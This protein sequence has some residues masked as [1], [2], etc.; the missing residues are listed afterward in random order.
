MFFRQAIYFEAIDVVYLFIAAV[1]VF[2]IVLVLSLSIRRVFRI[3]KE[4]FDLP[5][6]M[7]D[8]LREVFGFRSPPHF[9]LLIPL[10]ALVVGIFLLGLGEGPRSVVLGIGA[11]TFAIVTVC[12]ALPLWKNMHRL[13]ILLH[14]EAQHLVMLVFPLVLFLCFAVLL[15]A[16]KTLRQDSLP[17]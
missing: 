6:H 2:V 3:S 9:D 17:H 7:I 10:S 14:S 15:A 13:Q 5:E 11:L 4:E 16:G 1:E 8:A 12:R